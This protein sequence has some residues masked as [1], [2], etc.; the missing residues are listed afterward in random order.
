MET[1]GVPS[2]KLA[3]VIRIESDNA[4]GLERTATLRKTKFPL[5]V[6]IVLDAKANWRVVEL[7]AKFG[8]PCMSVPVTSNPSTFIT[9]ELYENVNRPEYTLSVVASVC[10]RIGINSVSPFFAVVSG[11]L[12][13]F[14][15]AQLSDAEKT[16]H[17]SAALRSKHFFILWD[18]AALDWVS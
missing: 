6:K 9:P 7:N 18:I 3:L 4:E 12:M 5:P 1:A 13:S 10:T 14:A 8:I 16:R 17:H 15:C 11:T 2:L